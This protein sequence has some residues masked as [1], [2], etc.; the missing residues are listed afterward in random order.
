MIVDTAVLPGLLL[1]AAELGVL[2][3]FGYVVARVA[4]RQD[5]DL[6]ALAQGLVVGPALWGLV[7]NFVMYAVPGLA[8]AAVGWGITLM[9]GAGLAWRSPGC[10]R[11]PARTVAGFAGVLLVL[12]WVALASRQLL[13]VVA[14]L[15]TSLGIAASIR[16][17]GFPVALSWHPEATA[18]YHYGAS[19][20]AGLLTPPAGPDL[21]FVWE[22]LGVY[23]WVSFALVVGTALR[24]RGSW[25]IVLTLA[26][27]LLGFGVHTF[28]WHDLDKVAGILSIPVP[29]GVPAAGLRATLADIYWAPVEPIGSR[30]GSL[31]DVWNLGFP[32]GYATAVVTLGQA[33]RANR[34]RWLG[35]L[36]LAGLVGFLGLL[37]TTLAPVV[38]VLWAGLAVWRLVHVRRAGGALPAAAWPSG[39]GLAAAGVLLQFG[40]GA[41]SGLV[42]G[43]AGSSGLTW[44]GGLNATHW[45]A[46][47]GV[48]AREGGIGLLRLGPLAVA[49][50][51]A[52]LAW[53]DRLVL[54]LA[55]GAVL[56]ALAWLALDYP[57]RPEDVD[58]LAGHARNLALVALL[59]ALSGQL[60]RLESRRW[61][62]AAVGLLVGLVVWPTV[63]APARSLG[64]ALGQGV[65]LANADGGWAATR[66]QDETRPRRYRI[67]AMSGR[68][69]AYIRDQ[70]DVDAH[71]L[72]TSKEL[73][74]LLNT[75][76]PTNQGFVGVTQLI[77]DSGPEYLDA[78]SYLEPAAFRRLG[79]AYVYA[80]DAWVAELPERSRDWLANPSYFNLLVRDGHEALY[81]VQ[82][83]FPALEAAPH[84]D[85]FEA[86]RAVVAPETVVYLSPR[87]QADWRTRARMLRVASVLPNARLVGAIHPTELHLRTPAPWVVEPLG[88]RVPELVALPLLHGAWQFPPADWRE[89][90]RNP[91]GGIAVYAPP[92]AGEPLPDSAPPT[93]HV[94]LANVQADETRLTFTATLEAR[95]G[96]EWTGQDW[97]LVPS[98]VSP[99]G[100][101][102]LR[103]D[104]R[105]LIAQWFAGQAA[106]GAE[107]TTHTYVFDPL[108]ASLAVRGTDGVF[109]AVRSSTQTPGS[110][111]WMLALR[112][113]R[114]GDQGIQDAVVIAPVLRVEVSPD[115]TASYQVYEAT[116][117]WRPL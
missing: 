38:L 57:P 104:G 95:K 40:G 76:R 66:A 1:L 92:V 83:A 21:A 111:A 55:T 100:I 77:V 11:V 96:Q 39:V 70:T 37:V 56:L 68:V 25:L 42:G 49:M 93:I 31:P 2:A 63:A 71:V 112:L 47:G 20:L 17:G 54:A 97:V 62:Y 90:W 103:Q 85:S 34:T 89:V 64:G 9:L 102:A 75:G 48:E 46:L 79:L 50:V 3:A 35:S 12:G 32:L 105:P 94:G 84:P 80:T 101:P 16:A 27:M 99:W 44:T 60:V 108:A 88:A 23:A 45:S 82:P 74:V 22:L 51:A 14:D 114:P 98:G 67:P 53:R 78:G 106:A 61:R 19:L 58:R 107:S 115:R 117:G 29:V 87:S 5:D 52:A 10:L 13:G 69:A 113:T 8:G 26:P 109:T 59:L 28:L 36:T 15:H 91:P 110:G 18:S 33:A 116:R 41:L 7:V 43:G 73:A 6:S 30:L 72:D 24:R 81:R 86:L 65:E 4:L